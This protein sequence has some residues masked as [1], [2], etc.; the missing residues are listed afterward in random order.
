V[1]FERC[2]YDGSAIGAEYSG[3]SLLLSCETCG[4]A[5]EVHNTLVRRVAAPDWARV[6]AAS[7]IE[8]R[9]NLSTSP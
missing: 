1:T 3:G 6:R 7:A 2:P 9:T 8:A 4:A 5:W